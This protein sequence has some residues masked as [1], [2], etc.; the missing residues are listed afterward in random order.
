MEIAYSENILKKSLYC[1]P[2]CGDRGMIVSARQGSS[3]ISETADQPLG[4]RE[5]CEKLK[6]SSEQQVCR[7]K[8]IVNERPLE[9]GQTGQS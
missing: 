1:N 4:C 6:T 3:S 8:G 7:Q 9:K 2:I 5:W